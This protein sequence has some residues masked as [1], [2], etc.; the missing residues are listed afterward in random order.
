MSSTAVEIQGGTITGAGTLTANLTSQ[1]TI[2]PGEA[3]GQIAVQGAI[4]LLDDS[5]LVFELGGTTPITQYDVLTTTGAFTLGGALELR[6]ANDF[7][8]AVTS[9]DTFTILTA[10]GA[11]SSFFT[12]ISSGQRLMTA[13]GLGS[14]LVTANGQSVV[15]SSFLV[16]EPGSIGLILFGAGFSLTRRS[17]RS[18][19]P[20]SRSQ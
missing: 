17:R 7:Q 3:I 12:N 16:P 19:R 1:G 2:A 20:P 15:L 14:F 18:E 11:L 6:F 9:A 5:R 13:D 8:N 4:S 10:G